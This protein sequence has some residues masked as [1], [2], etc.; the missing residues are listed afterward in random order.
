MGSHYERNRNSRGDSNSLSRKHLALKHSAARDNQ[1]Q[2]EIKKLSPAPPQGSN[3]LPSPPIILPVL[4]QEEPNF[5][6]HIPFQKQAMPNVRD[7]AWTS[8][9]DTATKVTSNVGDGINDHTNM[10]VDGD[11]QRKLSQSTLI[12]SK[13][14]SPLGLQNSPNPVETQ[15]TY[16]TEPSEQNDDL[17]DDENDKTIMDEVPYQ[18]SENEDPS[19]SQLVKEN[20]PSS[21]NLDA[22]ASDD[23]ESEVVALREENQRLQEESQTAAQQLK[24]FTEWFFQTVQ[25]DESTEASTKESDIQSAQ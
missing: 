21:P 22:E 4:P 24:R 3:T 8:L 14:S 20:S 16:F 1:R 7:M 17:T 5:E 13:K 11:S 19:D 23:L 15:V 12:N 10:Y 25:T 18:K 9:V 2:K 6:G